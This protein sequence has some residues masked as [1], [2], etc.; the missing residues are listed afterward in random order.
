M[1]TTNPPGSPT[2]GTAPPAPPP[3]PKSIT[4]TIAP[5]FYEADSD[6]PEDYRKLIIRLI[7]ETGEFTSTKG[8]QAYLRELV[9]RIIDLAPDGASRLRVADFYADESR[10]GFVFE[11]LLKALGLDPIKEFGDGF[12]TSIEALHLALTEMHTWTDFALATCLLDRVSAF[13][14]GATKDCSYA[15]LARVAPGIEHDE[16]GH[17]AMGQLH[18]GNICKTEAG[19]KEAQELLKKWYPLALDTFGTSTGWRQFKYLELGIK[20]RTNEEMRQDY[21]REVVPILRGM[22]LEPPDEM[23]NRKFV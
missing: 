18:L 11:G 20:T 9:T 21:I 12:L 16:R 19:R 14:F 4:R 6:M 17:S 3:D 7:K 15:P 8:F 23:F 5:F 10:H 22:G 1:T 2:P 13:S